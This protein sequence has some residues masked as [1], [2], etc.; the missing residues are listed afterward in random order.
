MDAF[1]LVVLVA[2]AVFGLGFLLAP[3]ILLAPLGVKLDEVSLALARMLG[4]AMLS[5]PVLL[6]WA[7]RST[8]GEFKR[9]AACCLL[10]YFLVSTVVLALAERDGAMNALGWVLV[11]V[12]A[13]FA[14]GFACVVAWTRRPGD[15]R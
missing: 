13:V 3:G 9:G 4:S 15:S 1:F 10:A 14:G 8:S 2:E 6:W 7:R 12:H 5:F 11:A